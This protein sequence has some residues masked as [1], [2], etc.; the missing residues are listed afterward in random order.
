MCL[1][2]GAECACQD[3]ADEVARCPTC[4]AWWP[5]E[6]LLEGFDDEDGVIINGAIY[7]PSCGVLGLIEESQS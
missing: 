2:L 5:R 7:C 4:G 1:N 3:A 6:E